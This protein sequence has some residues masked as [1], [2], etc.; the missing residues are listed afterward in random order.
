MAPWLVAVLLLARI[1]ARLTGRLVE[2][3]AV[4]EGSRE[5]A[6]GDLR[7]TPPSARPAAAAP[8]SAG[9]GEAARDESCEV[10]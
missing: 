2:R 8:S 9:L 4:I 6:V 7:R 3:L 10:A 1:A 5:G